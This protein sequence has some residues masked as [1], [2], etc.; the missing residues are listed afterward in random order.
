M[1]GRNTWSIYL[2]IFLRTIYFLLLVALVGLA[3]VP[4]DSLLSTLVEGALA[5]VFL[6]L[7]GGAP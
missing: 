3:I 7:V 2:H 1:T 6:V 4:F 5:T